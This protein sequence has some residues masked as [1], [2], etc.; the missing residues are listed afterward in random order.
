M[1]LSLVNK[2]KLNSNIQGWNSI[3]NPIKK[4]LVIFSFKGGQ[5]ELDLQ[6]GKISDLKTKTTPPNEIFQAKPIQYDNFFYLTEYIQNSFEMWK[7]DFK[8]MDWEQIKINCP[9]KSKVTIPCKYNDEIIFL[10]PAQNN[11]FSFDL[12][13]YSWNLIDQKAS[14]DFNECTIWED[15]LFAN[16]EKCGDFILQ[17]YS[18]RDQKWNDIEFDNKEDHCGRWG[19]K[20]ITIGDMVVFCGGQCADFSFL[21]VIYGYNMKEKEWKILCED[22]IETTICSVTKVDDL[23]YIIVFDNNKNDNLLFRYKIDQ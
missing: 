3:Y 13:L 20:L 19:V 11:V 10:E 5:K 22:F 9:M 2:K 17:T 23:L 12:N 6:T 21:D 7:F 8:C 18:F 4:N 14:D 1:K 15:C 16:G